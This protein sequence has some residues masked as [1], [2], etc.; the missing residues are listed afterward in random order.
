MR[1]LV[2]LLVLLIATFFVI[3]IAQAADSDPMGSVMREDARLT[4]FMELVAVADL[5]GFVDGQGNYTVLAPT[6]DAFAA[7]NG[8]E[9]AGLKQNA[10]EARKLVLYHTLHGRFGSAELRGEGF[11][12]ICPRPQRSH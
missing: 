10:N 11:G 2:S 9:L 4:I 7:M 3:S 1:R 12:R 6:N 8:G 5:N